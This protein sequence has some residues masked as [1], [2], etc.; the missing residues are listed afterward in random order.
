MN[1]LK[2][3]DIQSFGN[4]R[5]TNRKKTD[6]YRELKRNID[7]FGVLQ[8]ITYQLI[9]GKPVVLDGHQRLQI[10][11]ELNH[12]LI[13]AYQVDLVE[14]G[15]D[16]TLAQLMTNMNRVKLTIWDC[17]I[18]INQMAAKGVVKTQKQLQ[19]LFGRNRAFIQVATFLSNIE[20]KIFRELSDIATNYADDGSLD[21][22]IEDIVEFGKMPISK[23]IRFYDKFME[24][25]GAEKLTGDNIYDFCREAYNRLQSG[26]ASKLLEFV[27]LEIWRKEEKEIGVKPPN[28]QNVLFDEYIDTEIHDDEWFLNKVMVKHTFAGQELFKDLPVQENNEYNDRQGKTYIHDWDLAVWKIKDSKSIK[29]WFEDQTEV[30]YNDIVITEWNGNPLKPIIY[31]E[32]KKEMEKAKDSDSKKNDN[33]DDIYRLA[34]NKINKLVVPIVDSVVETYKQRISNMNTPL[35]STFRFLLKKRELTTEV[36]KSY[37]FKTG[38]T[39]VEDKSHPIHTMKFT[40][41]TFVKVMTPYWFERHY[42]TFTYAEIDEWLKEVQSSKTL[43]QYVVDEFVKDKEF[44][45]NFFKCYSVD[46]LQRIYSDCKDLNNKKRLV[47]HLMTKKYTTIPAVLKPTVMYAVPNQPCSIGHYKK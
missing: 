45:E 37:N 29:S 33:K 6:E 44:R 30:K 24:E 13:P 19:A 8:P 47:E 28:Y 16:S 12:D 22:Y 4:A 3:K 9:D 42:N 17:A 23:Q 11:K 15:M 5:S 31:Y 14:C 41:T 32:I 26:V 36:P 7:E 39:V 10:V 35:D 34:Y 1:T 2:I 27:P 20:P 38:K 18:G 40:D 43:Y 46:A 21:D 25:N